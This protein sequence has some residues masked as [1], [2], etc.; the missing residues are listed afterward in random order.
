MEDRTTL[1]LHVQ[2]KKFGTNERSV[3]E[4]RLERR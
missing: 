1:D 4:E 3:E 2:L